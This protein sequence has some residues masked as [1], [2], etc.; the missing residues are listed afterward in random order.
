ML[1]PKPLPACSGRV[2]EKEI[3]WRYAENGYRECDLLLKDWLK[4]QCALVPEIQPVLTKSIQAVTQLY[5]YGNY[6]SFFTFTVYNLLLLNS[7]NMKYKAHI[8]F[9]LLRLLK[10]FF[11][12]LEPSFISTHICVLPWFYSLKLFVLTLP[13]CSAELPMS[14]HWLNE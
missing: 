5:C 12:Y 14:I 2:N 8:C 10:N 1:A 6:M 11:F 13:R 7:L 4:L 9:S 3:Y